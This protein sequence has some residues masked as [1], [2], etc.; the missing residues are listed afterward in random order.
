MKQNDWPDWTVNR[1]RAPLAFQM[2]IPYK[3]WA[4]YDEVLMSVRSTLTAATNSLTAIT[5]TPRL[6]AELLMAEALRVDRNTL[7]MHHLDSPVPDDFAPLL[8]RRLARE[9]VA[10]ITGRRDFWTLTLSV[11]PAVLIPRPE[12]ETLIEVGIEWFGDTAPKTILDLGTGS[13]ALLLSALSHWRAAEGIGVDASSAALNIAED[14][15]DEYDLA[16]R[17]KF[18]LGNWAAGIDG[19][20]DFILCN[21]P[22]ICTDAAL[23]PEVLSEPHQALYGGADGLSDYRILVPQISTLIGKGGCACVEFGYGLGP[24][25]TALF[26]AEGMAVRSYKDLAGLDRCLRITHTV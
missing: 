6:D 17:A 15:A 24:A 25:I 18:K 10:Y 14:N 13:G 4:N 20:F 7:L 5:E 21:P 16:D 1:S 2:S 26:E 12:S 11:S 22:Y 8:E 19:P 3:S 9:P 23:E